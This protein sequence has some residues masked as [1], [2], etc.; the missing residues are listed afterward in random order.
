MA[1]LQGRFPAT[2]RAIVEATKQPEPAAVE[3]PQFQSWYARSLGWLSAAGGWLS[4]QVSVRPVGEVAGDDAGARVARAE[5]RL[6]QNDLAAA[7]KELEG[8][9]EPAASAAAAAWLGDARARL[10][11]D[12]VVSHLQ[13]AAVTRLGGGAAGTGDAGG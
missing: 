13:A 2:A 10:A 1:E 4:S 11:A 8:L 7:V 9:S 5:V 12:Q 3:N 6:A